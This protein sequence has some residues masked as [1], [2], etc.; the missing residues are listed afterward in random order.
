MILWAMTF[1]LYYLVPKKM[2]WYVLLVSSVLFYVIG[3]GGFPINL[4]L[5][6]VTTYGCGIYLERLLA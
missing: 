2:Q 4:L 3:L 1:A 6:G 5:T